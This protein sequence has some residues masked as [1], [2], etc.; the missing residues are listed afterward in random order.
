MA[1][2]VRRTWAPRGQTPVLRQRGKH[3]EKV[4]VAAALWVSPQRVG[5]VFRTLVNDYFNNHRLAAF[6]ELLMREISGRMIVIW[7]GGSMHKGDPIRETVQRF[8]PRL[9]LERLPAYAPM[10]NPVEPIWSWLK[11]ERLSNFA[12]QDAQQLRKAVVAELNA[13]GQNQEILMNF[14]HASDLPFP[15]HYFCGSL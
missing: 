2:L 5:L 14:W 10:L 7:D 1:P 4:S 6:L 8:A 3:R 13:I 15:R 12:P 9:E 11:Y